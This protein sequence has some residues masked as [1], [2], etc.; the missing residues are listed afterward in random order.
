MLLDPVLAAPGETAGSALDA[1]LGCEIPYH[2][3][4]YN[5]ATPAYTLSSALF[6]AV[7]LL[8]VLF[9]F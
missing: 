4:P 8:G 2:R 9:M 5:A 3:T 6:G 7:V 1:H